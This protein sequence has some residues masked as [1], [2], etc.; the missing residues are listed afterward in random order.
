MT[1]RSIRRMRPPPDITPA[2]MD[3]IRLALREDDA[4]RDVT[5]NALVPAAARGHA[6]IR[7]KEPGVIAGAEFAFHVFARLAEPLLRPGDRLDCWTYAIGGTR[8]QPGDELARIE[9]SLRVLLAGER[10]AVNLVQRMSGI[11]TLTARFVDAVAGSARDGKGGA[12][13]LATRKTAP[14]L[15]AFDLAAVRAGGGDVHRA[16]LADRVLVKKNHLEA[17]RAAG[18]AR[19]MADV[20]ALLARQTPDCPVGIEAID[21]DELRAALVPGVEVVLLDN[22]TPQRCAE[23]VRVRDAAFP[24]GG[25]PQLEASGGITLANVRGFAESGVERISVGALTHSAPALDV[26]MRV[27][28]S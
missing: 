1:R 9:G 15:R 11:A 27:L 28:Q 18:T 19:T 24:G 17:A 25:G 8:V 5:S 22:F 21:L 6:V 10:T 23:A 7:A 26:S 4:S 16:S 13:I 3:A 12:R 2:Q 20:V 14:G